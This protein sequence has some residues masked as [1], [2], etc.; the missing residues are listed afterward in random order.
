MK[1]A[2]PNEPLGFA[3]TDKTRKQLVYG[4]ISTFER[5]GVEKLRVWKRVCGKQF[6]QITIDH[7]DLTL[8]EVP[9]EKKQRSK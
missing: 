3:W 9:Y 2:N 1:T 8:L 4:P 6:Q 7:D 5:N